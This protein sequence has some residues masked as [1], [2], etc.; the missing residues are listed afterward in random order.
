MKAELKWNYVESVRTWQLLLGNATVGLIGGDPLSWTNWITSE[1][2][3]S[4][5]SPLAL[6]EAKAACEKSVRESL[7]GAEKK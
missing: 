3:F 4:R 6:E 5:E 7:S 1:S 2:G